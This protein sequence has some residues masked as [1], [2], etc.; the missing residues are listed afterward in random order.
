MHIV[1]SMAFR[2]RSRAR[3]RPTPVSAQTYAQHHL[4]WFDLYDDQMGDIDA[5]G[6]L[7]GVK[8][9]KEMDAEKGSS[10]AGRLLGGFERQP[11]DQV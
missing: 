4:P 8:S 9:I 1:N 6:A 2:S 10:A 3:S 7:K 11:D 5:P